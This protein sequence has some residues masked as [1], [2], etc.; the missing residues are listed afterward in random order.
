M[1]L[2]FTRRVS[3]L[4]GFRGISIG[5]G[6][7]AV[8]RAVANRLIE[9]SFDEDCT[10]TPSLVESLRLS[11]FEA[12]AWQWESGLSS[13]PRLSEP[14]LKALIAAARDPFQLVER[15]VS[16]LSGGI[17]DL[18]GSDHPVLASCA[19]YFF[20]M[21][22]GKKIRPVMV[23]AVSYALN[24]QPSTASPLLATPQQRRL[25]EIT[26]MIHTASLFHDDVIDKATTRRGVPS[27]NQV[28]P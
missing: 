5:S 4:R 1:R 7:E 8:D 2:A 28:P 25:A 16:S 18:L 9:H 26:E 20:E 17:K 10:Y 13:V 6:I 23:L 19:K 22:G 15:D 12:S 24:S 27:V 3:S 21:D 14:E 11:P